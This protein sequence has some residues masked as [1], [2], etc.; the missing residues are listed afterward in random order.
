MGLFDEALFS[1]NFALG[2]NN[3]HA[4]ALAEK[5]L[6]LLEL[7]KNEQAIVWFEKSLSFNDSAVQ[8][9]LGKG[10]GLAALSRHRDALVCFETV[11]TIEP[12]NQSALEAKIASTA[13]LGSRS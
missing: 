7:G 12:D 5:G 2:I 10:L 4:E 3:R 9:W 13:K 8:S 6:S 11:L 1:I